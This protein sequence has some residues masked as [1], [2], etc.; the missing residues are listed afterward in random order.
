MWKG[1]SPSNYSKDRAACRGARHSWSHS[2]REERL[3][4]VG[5]G[6]QAGERGEGPN[7]DNE[8]FSGVIFASGNDP[9]QRE[10][11]AST[12]KSFASEA[13]DM[14]ETALLPTAIPGWAGDCYVSEDFEDPL[15]A[16]DSLT[17]VLPLLLRAGPSLTDL[18]ASRVQSPSEVKSPQSGFGSGTG[19]LSRASTKQDVAPDALLGA[20]E[21][22]FNEVPHW[23]Q[24]R[25]ARTHDGI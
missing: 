11:R 22:L 24:L 8:C 2:D 6:G 9:E 1:W 25:S 20:V 19:P 21:S 18:V 10:E 12:R 3:E 14:E 7:V 15:A 23:R 5:R 16:S 17:P 13:S 4:L